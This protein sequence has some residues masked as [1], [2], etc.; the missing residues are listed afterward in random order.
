MLFDLDY[1]AM[2]LEEAQKAYR[3]DEVPVGAVIV[4]NGKVIARAHNLC[5][6]A[7]DP[8][9]HAELLAIKEAAKI[10][11]G[12]LNGATL[13]VTMEPCPMCAGAAV[14]ARVSR[15]VFGAY[16]EIAGCCGSVADLCDH[17]FPHSVE[18]IGGIREDACV[19]LLSN[20]FREK[21]EK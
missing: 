9:A 16:D 17:W 10:L 14:N 15:I 18:V 21:R 1:M 20:F 4:H 5:K 6:A 3:E 7:K 8:T 19:E 12:W 11:G 13:Y 2:A